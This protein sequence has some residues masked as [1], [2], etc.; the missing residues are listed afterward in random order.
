[1]R[2]IGLHTRTV[3]C[4]RQIAKARGVGISALAVELLQ[5][6]IDAGL[7][8]RLTNAGVSMEYG[9]AELRIRGV[10]QD[11]HV[12][13]KIY[14]ARRSMRVN[15]ILISLL[16]VS[17]ELLLSGQDLNEVKALPQANALLDP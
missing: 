8:E 4:L 10:P 15:D 11:T 6:A 13:L 16:T 1:M 3:E 9:D 7:V 12:Q 2:A 14:A 5:R 17:I